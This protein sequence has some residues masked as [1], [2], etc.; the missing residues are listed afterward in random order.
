MWLTKETPVTTYEVDNNTV[1]NEEIH[2]SEDNIEASNDFKC[3][4]CDKIFQNTTM[5][6]E[7][8]ANQNVIPQLDGNSEN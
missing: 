3:H 7:H 5:L 1:M 8:M 2:D 4:L 6:N